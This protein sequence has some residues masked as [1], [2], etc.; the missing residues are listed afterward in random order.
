M[1]L[2]TGPY[3]GGFL[4]NRSIQI[5]SSC[6][7]KSGAGGSEVRSD[8][9]IPTIQVDC[10]HLLLRNSDRYSLTIISKGQMCSIAAMSGARR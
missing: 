4:L 3:E 7:R 8:R 1:V 10:M 2:G 5:R 6:P 9:S